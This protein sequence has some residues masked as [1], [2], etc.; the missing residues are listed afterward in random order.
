[1]RTDETTIADVLDIVRVTVIWSGTDI[2][3]V[4]SPGVPGM[5]E[6]L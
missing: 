1:M 6:I 2:D 4:L 5:W 3:S